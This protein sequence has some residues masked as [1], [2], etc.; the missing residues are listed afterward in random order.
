MMSPSPRV[1][2]GV[3]TCSW[4]GSEAKPAYGGAKRTCIEGLLSISMAEAVLACSTTFGMLK[5]ST[6]SCARSA[7][8]QAAGRLP[9][10][11]TL[12]Q[13]SVL[14]ENFSPADALASKKRRLFSIHLATVFAPLLL[15]PPCKIHHSVNSS[16]TNVIG[17]R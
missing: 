9:R 4:A 14:E 11:H 10:H 1:F 13:Y 6:S 16:P 12:R 5:S 2:V 3:C 8:G 7:L 15:T 17:K